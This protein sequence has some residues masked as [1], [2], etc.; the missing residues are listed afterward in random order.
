[1]R[2]GFFAW[3]NGLRIWLCRKLWHR[4]VSLWYRP[5][6]QLQ[7]NLKPGKSMCHKCSLKKEKSFFP[8]NPEWRA[9]LTKASPSYKKAVLW[10]FICRDAKTRTDV[11]SWHGDVISRPVLTSHSNKLSSISSP[12]RVSWKTLG[13]DPERKTFYI[14]INARKRDAH[15]MKLFSLWIFS[16][17]FYFT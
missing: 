17:L 4:L 11:P 8:P 16:I 12:D 5:H 3:L 10:E 14:L 6:L 2:V 13:H 7:F 9:C 15:S 1:M